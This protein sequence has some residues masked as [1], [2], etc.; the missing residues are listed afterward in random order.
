MKYSFYS[1]FHHTQL[2]NERAGN[3]EVVGFLE[4][5][6]STDGGGHAAGLSDF[7]I[8]V[9]DILVH[10]TS[11]VQVT[12]LTRNSGGVLL[13]LLA[14]MNEG[15]SEPIRGEFIDNDGEF[16]IQLETFFGPLV[17]NGDIVD[18]SKDESDT[19]NR[20]FTNVVN[21]V[22]HGELVVAT[23]VIGGGIDALQ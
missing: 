14:T 22:H 16:N 15:S 19:T 18:V 1:L 6:E 11:S 17:G 21:T 12:R 7:V 3:A 20:L 5:G 13:E 10:G 9:V 2:Y 8:L 4:N 23:N